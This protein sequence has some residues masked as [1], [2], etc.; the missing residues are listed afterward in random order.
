MGAAMNLTETQRVIIAD[1]EHSLLVT[2]PAGAGKTEVMARRAANAKSCGRDNILCLTFTNRAADSMRKRIR[3]LVPDGGI[4]ICTFHAF[5]SMLIRAESDTIGLPYDFII[6]DETDSADIIRDLL[7]S[8]TSAFSDHDIRAASS[9]MEA[10]R[11]AE[12]LKDAFSAERSE[13]FFSRFSIPLDTAVCAYQSALSD[14]NAMDFQ[15]LVLTAYAFLRVPEHIRRWRQAYD[16]IQVDEMQDT[17]IIEYDIIS[18]L[19]SLHKNLSLFGDIDQ[20]IYE[21]RG[22]CPFEIVSRFEQTFAPI[23]FLLDQ[24]FRSTGEITTC[25]ESF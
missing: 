6:L 3:S 4:T 5:C 13:R 25:A 9:E 8:R 17:D 16:F 22:S 18:T 14:I 2:A 10:F 1:I 15:S 19:A 21:W 11:R 12:A 23:V 20:T 24:N 7:P